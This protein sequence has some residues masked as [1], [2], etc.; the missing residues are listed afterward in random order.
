VSSPTSN[1]IVHEADL[2]SNKH[3]SWAEF[4]SG[5]CISEN[6]AS[7]NSRS[8]NKYHSITQLTENCTECLHYMFLAHNISSWDCPFFAWPI[9]IAECAKLKDR[10]R[11]WWPREMFKYISNKRISPAALWSTVDDRGSVPILASYA[12]NCLSQ[13]IKSASHKFPACIVLHA[14]RLPKQWL[15]AFY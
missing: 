3:A 1:Q 7:F 11:C 9:I 10:E 15:R 4:F 13:L 12:K 14:G 2:Q 6:P 8:P 5:R